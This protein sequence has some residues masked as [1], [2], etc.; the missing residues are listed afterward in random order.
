MKH[1][2]YVIDGRVYWLDR[3]ELGAAYLRDARLAQ[4]LGVTR[5]SMSLF[6]QSKTSPKD[7]RVS[8]L[9]EHAPACLR[10]VGVLQ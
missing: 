5:Q 1:K 3:Y 6:L 8:L 7:D 2:F 10:F 9:L 4:K